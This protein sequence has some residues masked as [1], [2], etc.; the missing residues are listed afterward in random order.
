M[1]KT[2][3]AAFVIAQAAC[4]M[5]EIAAMQAHNA[6]DERSGRVPLYHYGD[7]LAVQEKYTIGHNAVLGWLQ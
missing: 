3:R 6:A 5:A 2:E 7:F 4:A 1:D